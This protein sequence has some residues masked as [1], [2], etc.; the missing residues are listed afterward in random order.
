MWEGR[1]IRTSIHQDLSTLL[2]CLRPPE[3]LLPWTLVAFLWVVDLQEVSPVSLQRLVRRQAPYLGLDSSH[4]SLHLEAVRHET[5]DQEQDGG[6]LG[7]S[8]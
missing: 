3:P 2:D 5:P 8:N 1:G 7:P 6:S 4:Q